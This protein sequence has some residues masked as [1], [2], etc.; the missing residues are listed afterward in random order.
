ML[1]YTHAHTHIRIHTQAHVVLLSNSLRLKIVKKKHFATYKT[2][3]LL[4]QMLLFRSIF[5]RIKFK[6]IE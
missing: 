6:L 5:F 3:L 4:L 2:V 1:L